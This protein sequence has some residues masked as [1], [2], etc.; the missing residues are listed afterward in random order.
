MKISVDSRYKMMQGLFWM[1]YCV[2]PGFVSLYLQGRGLSNAGI[3]MVTA[4]FGILSTLFQPILGRLSDRNKGL[5]WR[6]MIL[7]LAVPC[8]LI[9]VILPLTPGVWAGSIF[10][11]LVILLLNLIMPFLNSAHYYYSLAGVNINF[12]V[13]RGIGSGSYA[14]L[15]IL[16]GTLA[17][18]FGI[19]MVP[20]TGIVICLFF[21]LVVFRMPPTAEPVHRTREDSV[22]QKG[23]LQ[24]YP[25]FSIMLVASML[26]LTAHNILNTYLLQ[27][28]QS[29]GGSSSQLGIALAI[30][31]IVEVP[32]LFSFSK[33]LKR[34]RARSLMLVAAFGFALK[35]LLY[36]LSVSVLMVYMIQFT[37]MISFAIFASASVFYTAEVIAEED[38]TTGQ[39]FM[40]SMM[41][42]GSVIGSL[43]GGWILELRGVRAMLSV[44]VLIAALGVAFAFVSIRHKSRSTPI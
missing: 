31:A 34:F 15:A 29:F 16:I 17:E 38:Q 7:M 42:A 14:L 27:I 5:D 10:M 21:I 35:A 19:E 2:S 11:G 4:L 6:R 43:I 22:V 1:L 28:I 18:K 24:R 20:I 41:T 32:V 23:F 33:L 9:C 3:G 44:N 12:G 40:T 8:L 25:E 26:M 30:Q 39:A 37:Q 13:A 36:A